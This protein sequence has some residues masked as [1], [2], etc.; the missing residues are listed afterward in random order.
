MAD[1]TFVVLTIA[2]FA[3]LAALVA[4]CDRLL[5]SAEPEALPAEDGTQRE[6]ATAGAE[7]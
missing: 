4:A 3:L 1:L 2:A 6:P 5:G 7:R